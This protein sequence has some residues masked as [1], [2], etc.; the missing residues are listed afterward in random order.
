MTGRVDHLLE[1]ARLA[2]KVL[3]SFAVAAWCLYLVVGWALPSQLAAGSPLPLL[4]ALALALPAPLLLSRRRG[5]RNPQALQEAWGLIDRAQPARLADFHLRL[6]Q[7]TGLRAA[8]RAAWEE[9]LLE[10]WREAG[11]PPDA[12]AAHSLRDLLSARRQWGPRE[13]DLLLRLPVGLLDPWDH[14]RLWA[15]AEAGGLAPDAAALAEIL[16]RLPERRPPRRVRALRGLLFN[17]A[18][19]G[20]DEGRA[21]LKSALLAHRIRPADLPAGLAYLAPEGA[22]RT[23]AVHG[24][25]QAAGRTGLGALRGLP[26]KWIAPAAAL[27]LVL[28]LWRGLRPREEPPQAPPVSPLAYAPP[29]GIRAG[30]TLQ[31]MSSRDSTASV[32]YVERLHA[33]SLYAYLLAPRR[34]SSWLRVRLGWFAE[35][36]AA[37]SV[38]GLLK[39]RGRIDEWYVAN[40]DAEGRLFETASPADS[41]AGRP[42]PR[43]R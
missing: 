15:R 41:T 22:G 17:L 39:R 40:F 6:Q 42:Q 21:L 2:G 34:N 43:E 36:A 28:A 38:G 9:R 18:G 13:R 4:I 35:R 25:V 8:D 24:A 27:L 31:I 32:R 20:H 29:A 7:Q 37:D 19:R 1:V 30:F 11:E 26:W 3:L 10:A 12:A 14:A 16:G 23:R 33:D 5:S